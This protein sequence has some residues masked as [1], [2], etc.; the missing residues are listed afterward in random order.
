MLEIYRDK[1]KKH[2]KFKCD[3]MSEQGERVGV[4]KFKIKF[5][6]E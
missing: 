1:G 5:N 6:K 4:L 2:K 3:M